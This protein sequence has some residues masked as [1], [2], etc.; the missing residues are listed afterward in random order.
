MALAARASRRPRRLRAQLDPR[1]D[2]DP[3]PITRSRRLR[4][5]G[6]RIVVGDRQRLQPDRRRLLDKRRR[7]VLAVRCGSMGMQVDSG[8]GGSFG[9]VLGIG[10]WVL[11]IGY[12][13]LAAG[14]CVLK[15]A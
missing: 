7:A 14:L 1:H 5:S 2:L 11:G 6:R 13:V 9:W 15:N 3:D 10:Y 4:H 8:H 12:W